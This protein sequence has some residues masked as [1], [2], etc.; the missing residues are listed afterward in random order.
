MIGSLKNISEDSNAVLEGE[1]P[2]KQS[3]NHSFNNNPMIHCSLHFLLYESPKKLLRALHNYFGLNY[4]PSLLP[5]I[6]VLHAYMVSERCSTKG[7]NRK[8]VTEL[9]T[10]IQLLVQ[11]GVDPLEFTSVLAYQIPF[12]FVGQLKSTNL[13]I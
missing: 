12:H 4:T 7:Y 8:P 9:F 11:P 2:T 3:G 13:W 5:N 6:L 10:G 1:L